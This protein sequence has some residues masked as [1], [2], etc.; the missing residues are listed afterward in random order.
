MISCELHHISALFQ[1]LFP[2]AAF[3]NSWRWNVIQQ[4][5]KLSSLSQIKMWLKGYFN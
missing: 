5:E 3:L 4:I 1:L 2:I